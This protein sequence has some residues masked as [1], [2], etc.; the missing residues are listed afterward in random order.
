MFRNM[1][2]GTRMTM[3]VG[4]ILLFLIVTQLMSYMGI[5]KVRGSMGQ[6]SA[7]IQQLT[8]SNDM[9]V[10]SIDLVLLG[11]D[12]IID[13]SSGLEQ[14]RKDQLKEYKATF[15]KHKDSFMSAMD[16]KEE[17]ADGKAAIA[18]FNKIF[19]TVENEL[20][21]SVTSGVKDKAVYDKYDNVID[22]MGDD[23]RDNLTKIIQSITLE[24]EE[25]E[26]ARKIAVGDLETFQTSS[27]IVGGVALFLGILL[28]LFSVRSVNRILKINIEALSESSGQVA[29]GSG[30]VTEASQKLASGA[31]EQ[32]ASLEEASATLEEISATTDNNASI[33]QEVYKMVEETYQIVIESNK[34]MRDLREAIDEINS[35]SEET[36]KII[37]VIDEIAFQTN[38]L[39]LNAAV[40][41]ARAGEAGLG[42]AVVADEVRNLAQRSAE[43]AKNTAGLIDKSIKNIKK[44]HDLTKQTETSF[45]WV[46]SNTDKL[47]VHIDELSKAGQEQA[48]SIRQIVEMVSS[49]DKVVQGNAA[50]SEESAAAAEEM[51]AQSRGLLDIVDNLALLVGQKINHQ[52]SRNSHRE[53]QNSYM[54]EE[55]RLKPVYQQQKDRFSFDNKVNQREEFPMEDEMRDEDF[56]DMSTK[57]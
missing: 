1:K 47:K 8:V 27:I 57:K 21:V 23:L 46:V 45:N 19:H 14:Q 6:H 56:M 54:R 9:K 53:R 48:M 43:A 35:S 29:S 13:Y 3:T 31:S 18:L 38:L 22:K 5:G 11:M 15:N 49:M 24:V 20:F 2:I 12:V 40:E 4:I 51:N 39:A 41:A 36:G 26:K 10:L 44:G 30:Q 32:A 28:A 37:K 16:T 33:S 52:K 50:S 34:S 17:I 7:R 55:Q 42:F 25:A